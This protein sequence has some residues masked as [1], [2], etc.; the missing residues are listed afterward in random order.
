[1]T[2]IPERTYDW[3]AQD[4]EGNVWYLGEDDCR[5]SSPTAQA[6]LRARGRPASTGPYPGIIMEAQ[7][8]DPRRLSLGFFAGEAEDTAWV[9]DLGVAVRCRRQ[10]PQ[11]V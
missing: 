4:K 3:Y 8:A 1:M 11:C 2:N 9:V 6:I 10:R 5:T 7:A